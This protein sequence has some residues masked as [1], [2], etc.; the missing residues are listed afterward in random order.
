MLRSR[1][2]VIRNESALRSLTLI[3]RREARKP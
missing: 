1:E 3:R 2:M